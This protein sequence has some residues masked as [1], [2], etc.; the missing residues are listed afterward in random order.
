[1]STIGSADLTARLGRVYAEIGLVLPDTVTRRYED[2]A[3]FL[4]HDSHLFD[5]IDGRQAASCLN[6]GAKA[7]RRERIPVHRDLEL[8]FS[9]QY[10]IAE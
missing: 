5:A 3:A 7:C 6:I 8:G 10:R 9:G 2:V 4:V 1:M